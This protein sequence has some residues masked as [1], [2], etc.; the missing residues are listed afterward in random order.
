MIAY[1]KIVFI[2]DLVKAETV[3][4]DD[5][6]LV[7]VVLH[8]YSGTLAYPPIEITKTRMEKDPAKN[9]VR[10]FWIC[11]SLGPTASGFSSTR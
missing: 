4:Q 2:K 10:F 9:L 6:N 5:W 8:L 11:I 3:K 7:K 1:V